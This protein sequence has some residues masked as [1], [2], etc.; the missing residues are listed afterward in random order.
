MARIFAFQN[1]LD[2]TLVAAVNFCFL[3]FVIICMECKHKTIRQGLK[4]LDR[5]NSTFN[6]PIYITNLSLYFSFFASLNRVNNS[7][8]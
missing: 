6:L 1:L 7:Q 3:S 5:K 8:A 4:V 2:D